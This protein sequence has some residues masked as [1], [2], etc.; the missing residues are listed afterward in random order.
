MNFE[1]IEA[2][3]LGNF[4][5]QRLVFRCRSTASLKGKH[6]FQGD[7]HLYSFPPVDVKTGDYLVVYIRH[8]QMATQKFRD[9]TC[10]FFY[11]GKWS[12]LWDD[13]A[14]SGFRIIA[15]LP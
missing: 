15:H 12:R 5:K 7:H 11:C 10:H 14:P 3:D 9:A 4:G 2:L 8:G 13:P 1:F 6:L